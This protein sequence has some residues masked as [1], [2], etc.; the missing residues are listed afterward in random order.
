M[1]KALGLLFEYM[2]VVFGLGF[3][4]PLIAQVLLRVGAPAPFGVP[5]LVV[6]LVV[7]PAWGLYAKVRGRWL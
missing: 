5:A 6:G 4:A 2:P 3:V 1:Q 7:G